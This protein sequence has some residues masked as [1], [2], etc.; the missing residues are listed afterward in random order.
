ME[1]TPLY[2]IH[3]ELPF[4]LLVVL[5]F[6]LNGLSV[7]LFLVSALSTVFGWQKARQLAKPAAAM[8][9]ALLMPV[10]LV[11][12]ADL[13]RPSRFLNLL[14]HYNPT[15]VMSW[16]GILLTLYGLGCLVYTW[17]LWRDDRRVRV[18]GAVGLALAAGTVLY[19]GMLLAVVRSRPL[20]NSALM[21]V[22][23]VTSGLAAGV[24]LVTVAA[25]WFPRWTHLEGSQ[26]GEVL[27]PLNAWLAGT[28]LVLIAMHFVVLATGNAAGQA[29]VRHLLA[30]PR[31]FSFVWLQVL[32]GTLLPLVLLLL[33]S[34]GRSP[35]V[36]AGASLLSLLGVFALRYNLVY[37]G[38][39][40][41]LTGAGLNHANTPTAEWVGFTVLLGLGIVLA[42]LVPSALDRIARKSRSTVS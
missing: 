37:G 33:S 28:Q 27:R 38:A 4:G 19:P 2:E 30:G 5:D 24:S 34:R 32:L 35:S 23:F 42:V 22:L 14:L 20:W 25:A 9:L 12:I 31:Q 26:A 1:L 18:A 8:A 21:P 13:G 16:G 6:F 11:L 10:P 39:E 3:H 40:L 36:L 29:A 7:G 15:S 41:P 17:L